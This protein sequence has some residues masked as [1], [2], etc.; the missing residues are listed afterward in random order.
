MFLH[1]HSSAALTSPNGY[2]YGL[3]TRCSPQPIV[4]SLLPLLQR[5]NGGQFDAMPFPNTSLVDQPKWGAL[6]INQKI[7]NA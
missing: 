6:S 2:S 5:L 7:M 4:N 1:P 3:P